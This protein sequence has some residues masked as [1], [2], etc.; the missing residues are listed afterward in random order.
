MSKKSCWV[1]ER[2]TLFVELAVSRTA[3][4]CPF[5]R[6][7]EGWK[8]ETGIFLED[9]NLL[10]CPLELRRREL[11]LDLLQ[12]SEHAIGSGC[13][14]GSAGTRLPTVDRLHKGIVREGFWGALLVACECEKAFIYRLHV[15]GGADGLGGGL[16]GADPSSGLGSADPSSGLGGGLGGGKSVLRSH[17]NGHTF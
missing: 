12:R 4:C 9:I 2:V 16:A 10:V 17:C 5:V 15:L 7:F 8:K 3:F 1:R 11:S 6:T 13:S 14:R